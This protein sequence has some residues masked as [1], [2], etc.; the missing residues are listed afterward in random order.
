MQIRWWNSFNLL[1]VILLAIGLMGLIMGGRMVFDPGRPSSGY[2]MMLVNG[3]LP[4]A[5]PV[6]EDD[7]SEPPLPKRA[8]GPAVPPANEG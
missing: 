5:N 4:P 8:D 2:A 3:F 7:E 6:H 1:A